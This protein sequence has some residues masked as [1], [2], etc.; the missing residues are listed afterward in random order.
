[1]GSVFKEMGTDTVFGQCL[2]RPES[3]GGI[4]DALWL[5]SEV[6]TARAQ[7]LS[8]KLPQSQPRGAGLAAG[9]LHCGHIWGAAAGPGPEE[10]TW[11][12]QA[13]P[14]AY[15]A[16]T[17]WERAVEEYLEVRMSTETCSTVWTYRQ[18]SPPP[19]RETTP[20]PPHCVI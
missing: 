16:K 1:M 5:Q 8:P 9:R 18:V 6:G 4:R 13:R 14:G 12:Q 7:G 20:P 15:R 3:W 2:A 10:I 11:H 19:H 17:L